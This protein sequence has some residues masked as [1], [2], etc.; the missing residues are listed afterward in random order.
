MHLE[1][2][3]TTAAPTTTTEMDFD[4]LCEDL[5]GETGFMPDPTY[6]NKYIRCNHGVSQRFTCA[7]GTVWDTENS[8]CLWS[9]AVDCAEREVEEEES[10]EEE[11]E[12]DYYTDEELAAMEE[13]A[14]ETTE[15]PTSKEIGISLYENQ[16]DSSN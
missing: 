13:E 11:Y 16:L 14:N 10:K 2:T 7:A 9:E 15:E 5:P 3:T 1:T 8:M 6:C 12:Y 4:L